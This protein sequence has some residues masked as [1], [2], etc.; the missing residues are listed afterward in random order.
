MGARLVHGITCGVCSMAVMA[1][2]VHDDG[3]D[4]NTDTDDDVS[5]RRHDGRR[6]RLFWDAPVIMVA[7]ALSN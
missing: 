3:D 2:S 5:R 7:W 6:R 1:R 4:G